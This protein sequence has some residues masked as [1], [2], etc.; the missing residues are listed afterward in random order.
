MSLKTFASFFQMNNAFNF[1][2]ILVQNESDKRPLNILLIVVYPLDETVE[3]IKLILLPGILHTVILIY[4][5][6]LF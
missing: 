1:K 6:N 2:D 3:I 5:I 4:K